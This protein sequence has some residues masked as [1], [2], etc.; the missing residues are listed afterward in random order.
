MPPAG[1]GA[2]LAVGFELGA[3][4]ARVHL[5]WALLL[6][7]L[8]AW[9]GA[10]LRRWALA[11]FGLASP[12][13]VASRRHWRTALLLLS[14]LFFYVA[15]LRPRTDPVVERVQTRSRDLV[16]C[17]DVSRSMLADDIRPNRLERA[18]LELSRLADA[19][20]GDRMG[21]IVF[22]GDAVA[23][24][25]LT[26]NTSYLKRTLRGIS[27]RSANQGGTRIGDAVRKALADVLGLELSR[28]SA[29]A[30]DARPEETAEGEPTPPTTGAGPEAPGRFADIL[31]ITD[32]EDH[33]SYPVYA[34]RSAGALGVGIYA[35]GLGSP[36]GHTIPLDDGNLLVQD[37]QPVVTKLDT[38]TLLEMVRTA[39]RGRVLPVG[40]DNFDLV[41]FW[42]QHVR[43]QPGR[44]LEEERLVWTEVFQ[45][46]VLT[47][48]ALLL[49]GW[50]IP[51]R[52]LALLALVSGVLHTGP[53]F[54]ADGV[55]AV[56]PD[57]DARLALGTRR[58]EEGDLTG[59]AEAWLGD[60]TS[61]DA[62]LAFNASVALLRAG[63][64]DRAR[65]LLETAT[66]DGNESVRNRA[67]FN[68]GVLLHTRGDALLQE[69]AAPAPA[70]TTGAQ[71]PAA[72][73]DDPRIDALRRAVESYA[74]AQAFYR[75]VRPRGE[76]EHAAITA[77][78]VRARQALDALRRLEEQ[79]RARDEAALLN[80]PPRLLAEV[81][82]RER[83]RRR[84]FAR[85]GEASLRARRPIARRSRLETAHDR[86]LLG[87]LQAALEAQ[88][89]ENDAATPPP[90]APVGDS[91]PPHVRAL[92]M[93]AAAL[94]GLEEQERR[95]SRAA[96]LETI[97]RQ[98]QTIESLLAARLAWP[99]DLARAIAEL[100][101]E[102]RLVLDRTRTELA[103]ARE[104]EELGLL[105]GALRASLIPQAPAGT[106]PGAEGRGSAPRG[107]S[108]SAEVIGE[109]RE[110]AGAAED[111]ARAATALI[112]EDAHTEA[113]APEE[114]VLERL[115]AMRELLP[116]PLPERLRRL[117][118][119][120]RDVEEALG[121]PPADP[122]A[123]RAQH[124]ELAS[125]QGQHAAEA[126][127]IAKAL[128][129]AAGA[130]A[131]DPE[132]GER[133]TQAAGLVQE[134][135][136]E[137]DATAQ[138]LERALA[139]PA[140]EA[141]GRAIGK[142]EEA[143]ER[144]KPPEQDDAQQ[145]Q[146]QEQQ[147]QEQQQQDPGQDAQ[148]DAAQDEALRDARKLSAREAR[149]RIEEQEEERR[150]EEARLYRGVGGPS[151]E[152][153]W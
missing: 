88:A 100:E 58:F 145:D 24:C 127:A 141:T 91:A 118:A 14:L 80:D 39:G 46:F 136:A 129:E 3:L 47:G 140:R 81:I 135:R 99:L 52:T 51:L 112:A 120:E 89:E 86:G 10:R 67:A 74:G 16:V 21:L 63:E 60:E 38:T 27:P 146:Q 49:A 111:A 56:A 142:L 96:L 42:R 147:Q 29:A 151:V 31:L 61:P 28:P 36:D 35:I 20:E 128:E 110:H 64:L 106:A 44:D 85:L 71:T 40:T 79:A 117:I 68:L 48:L 7:G 104:E 78:K 50:A 138:A 6:L 109:L 126:D 103:L 93:L 130:A 152:K 72:G 122:E 137:V 114:H 53:A 84:L 4:D 34:A 82:E 123:L 12:A 23:A 15:L 33:D 30:D 69:G 25:P 66:T 139:T 97:D 133:L 73:Q 148:R 9:R 41:D 119:A 43:D 11:A 45:P 22:A 131:G 144:L 2:L 102:Q 5:V 92:P 125:R 19:L 134:A 115:E 17:L 55:D 105:L 83:G 77:A 90:G 70:D 153:D 150:K 87:R 107:V 62:L 95:L 149:A 124:R 101:R 113:L 37:G 59:A 75:R 54:A 32:G 98:A 8:L 76:A 143:L 13:G 65:A 132:Q 1:G 26:A 94:A 108:L 57:R 18:K 121:A 116:L